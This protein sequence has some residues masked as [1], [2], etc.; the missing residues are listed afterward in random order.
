VF[1]GGF[2]GLDNIGVSTAAPPCPPEAT[3]SRRRDGLDGL[4][5]QNMLEIAIELSRARPR[6]ETW[7]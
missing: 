3:W 7:P 4:L 1:E 6:L 5:H 2:L